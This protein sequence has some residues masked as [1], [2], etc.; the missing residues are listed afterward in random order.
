MMLQLVDKAQET[1]RTVQQLAERQQQFEEITRSQS[2]TTQ[3]SVHQGRGVTFHE[4]LADP[5]FPR[6]R[7]NFSPDSP[8]AEGQEPAFQTPRART[9][10]AF[11]PPITS[12]MGSNVAT[13]SSMPDRNTGGST[14]L[15]PPPP[16]SGSGAG[17]NI[18]SGARTSASVFQARV[19]T[20]ST[21]EYQRTDADPAA[22]RTNLA[23]S[24]RTNERPIS[25]ASWEDDRARSHQEPARRVSDNDP[26][27]LPFEGP[28]AIRRYMERTHA[29]L[30]KLGAQVHKVTSS[31]PEIESLI[32]ETRGT[33]FTDRIANSYIRDTRKIKIP[34]YDG[35]ADPK[36]YLRAFRLAIVKAHFTKEEC[37]AG[38]CRT[39]AENLIGTALEWFSSLEPNSIDSFDQLANA[40]MKQYSTHILKQASEA[41]L[42]K[43]RQGLGDSLRVYIE[44]FRA[45][46]TKLS[47]PNDQVAIEALRRGLWYKSG[48]FSELTLNPPPTID[49]ALHKASRYI[50][51]E[52][53]MAALDK[54][55]RKPQSHPK[56]EASDGKGPHKRGSS[57]NNQTQG[58]HSYVVEEDK[59]EKPVAATAKAPW[60]K[61]YDESKH[62]S[63]HDRKGHSTEECWDLQRQL[64]AKFAAGEIKDVD[65]KKPQ[66]Y[67]KR[68]PRDSSPKRE[69]SPEKETDSPPPAPKMRVDMILGKFPQ[70]K[71]LQIEALLSKP[72]PQ[73]SPGSRIDYILGGSG[74]C[75]DSVNS[76]KSHV[77]KA[78]S[79]TQSK[80]TKPES[81]TKISFWESE[82][83]DLDRPHD[84]ALVITLN[85][86]GYEVPKLMIDTGSSVD[87][88]F[89]NA[90]KGME[91]DDYEIV[92]QKSNLV[93]F[94]GET[95]TSLGTIKL[96]IIAGGV[97]KMTNFIVVDKPSPFHAILGRPWIHKMKAVASTYHQCVKFPTTNGIATIHGS[98]K[99]SRICYLGGFEIIKES[100]Q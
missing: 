93:G 47:N 36:A 14:R 76:I 81:N 3:P 2:A 86:A 72:P 85:I 21:D 80:P 45:V 95:A 34:E 82:T 1:E 5:S 75:Q 100:P 52:E 84:D 63:Y 30:Q 27:V 79:N 68:G 16:P 94:S 66:P 40:F 19:S 98:Q 96:P 78:V 11:T 29:A 46:R 15:P 77:R 9:A 62:C 32:E 7:L 22:L 56:G 4:R 12:T 8:G 44:K 74:V 51:L 28:D 60:S 99:I 61:G 41:D 13:T 42:W 17:T 83:L 20:P 69:R 70:G 91:I 39:F 89:Y 59:E 65:L 54:L 43:I 58:E 92:D 48:F 31:A 73:S 26:N 50:T 90:L 6:E 88:I 38:Y 55:H 23:R 25:P 64:A 49:D 57:R 87:L 33:P 67:Q 71:S 35:N 53:E 10:P 24:L 18:P 37:D 97:M